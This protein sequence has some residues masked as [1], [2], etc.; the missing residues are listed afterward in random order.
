MSSFLEKLGLVYSRV[1]LCLRV[2]KLE[3]KYRSLDKKYNKLKLKR[4]RYSRSK[5]TVSFSESVGINQMLPQ[6]RQA[7][8]KRL[9][10]QGWEALDKEQNLLDSKLDSKYKEL[11][12]EYGRLKR[13]ES[14]EKKNK[15]W[16]EKK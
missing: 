10:R 9:R 3:L 13:E 4:L 7:H 5:I 11:D 2:K 1:S 14:L 8:L 16:K 6:D 15:S 12:R